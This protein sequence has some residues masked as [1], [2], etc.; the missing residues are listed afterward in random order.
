MSTHRL[1]HI[2]CPYCNSPEHTPWACELGFT[3]VRCRNCAILFCNPRPSLQA[4]DS[5]V[6]TGAHGEEANGLVVTARRISRKVNLYKTAF[7]SMFADRWATAKPVS[8]LDVG[9]GYGEVLEAVQQLAPANSR[10]IGLEPMHHKARAARALGLNIIE[11]YLRPG[12]EPVDVISV[13]DVFSHIPDFGSFLA[14][15]KA[16]LKPGGEVFIETGNLADLESREQFPGELGLPDH[17]VFAGRS[18][19]QGYLERAGFVQLQ[20]R[21]TRIDGFPNLCKN[22]VK[23]LI[24]RPSSIGV[25]YTSAYRQIQIRAQVRS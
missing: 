6:R 9:A 2:S 16:V 23:R 5:A 7:A 1:E 17:L 24:G 15:V 8:W 20:V 14:D 19:L 11:E 10:I 4:I 22:I 18:H 12:M 21:E 13:V 3:A 25:P